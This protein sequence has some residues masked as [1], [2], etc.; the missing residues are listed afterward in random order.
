MRFYRRSSIFNLKA[1]PKCFSLLLQRKRSHHTN[2]SDFTVFY[3]GCTTTFGFHET[4]IKH[5]TVPLNVSSVC[6]ISLINSAMR[7]LIDSTPTPTP[8]PVSY[9]LCVYREL[10]EE[11]HPLMKE[12]LERRPEVTH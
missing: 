5:F 7:Q 10:V 6:L 12:A 11:L 4:H 2:P 9:D 8:S 3:D 1:L